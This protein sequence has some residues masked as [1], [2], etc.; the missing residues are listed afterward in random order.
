MG[1]GNV[2]KV[3]I[4]WPHLPHPAFRVLTQMAV[5]ALDRDNPPVYYGGRDALVRVLGRGDE[6]TDADYQALK[7][8][9]RGLLISG[10]VAVDKHAGPGHTTRYSLHLDPPTGI[11]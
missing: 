1:A 8:A 7:R 4:H 3:C 5:V 10:V 11:T 2:A 6:P 9:I